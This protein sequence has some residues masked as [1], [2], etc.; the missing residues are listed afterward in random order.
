MEGIGTHKARFP[1][2]AS[3]SRLQ[4]AQSRCYLHPLGPKA[5]INYILNINIHIHIYI[6][7]Y[8]Y[9]YIY[10]YVLRA[11][12]HLQKPATLLV[13]PL[14]AQS[15]KERLLPLDLL[16][17]LMQALPLECF[18]LLEGRRALVILSKGCPIWAANMSYMGG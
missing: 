8:V 14:Q 18:V 11:T 16:S 12:E 3:N 6:Y 1:F 5:R 13:A 7:V 2:S 15:E 10:V 17:L 4:I 9:I